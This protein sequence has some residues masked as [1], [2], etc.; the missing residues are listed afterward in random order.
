MARLGRGRDAPDGAAGVG[1][2][3]RHIVISTRVE[4]SPGRMGLVAGG[5]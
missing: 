1:I 4:K 5:A 3:G 2:G